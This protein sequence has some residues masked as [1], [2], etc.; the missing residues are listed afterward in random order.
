MSKEKKVPK[1]KYERELGEVDYIDG[2]KGIQDGIRALNKEELDFLNRFNNEFVRG[3]FE[4][5]KKN[6]HKELIAE[7]KEKVTE[8]R[9]KIKEVK[10]VLKAHKKNYSSNTMNR[11]NYATI[12]A[13]ILDQIH[14]LED[15]LS[16]YDVKGN[17][18]KD[19]YSRRMDIYHH[20]IMLVSDYMANNHDIQNSEYE[21][22]D[23]ILS[24]SNS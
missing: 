17:I 8:L 19:R 4:N 6:I 22:F 24:N 18:W 13:S 10:E 23:T 3:N 5:N 20:D 15:E 2:V 21:L 11:L 9:Q 14:S 7:N 1:R 12:K 16:L